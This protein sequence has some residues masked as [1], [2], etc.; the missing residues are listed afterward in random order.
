M[1]LHIFKVHRNAYLN[2][3]SYIHGDQGDG[4]KKM[5]V[6][7]W[8]GIKLV[9]L[10]FNYIFFIEQICVPLHERNISQGPL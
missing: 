2:I 5:S 4:E 6:L 8:E 9:V 3:F 1:Y 10:F 7:K